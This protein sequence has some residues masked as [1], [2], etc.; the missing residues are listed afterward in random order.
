[1]E[2]LT[3]L[4]VGGYCADVLQKEIEASREA[5]E[6]CASEGSVKSKYF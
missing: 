6:Q 4:Y 2:K 3:T 5:D 1:M